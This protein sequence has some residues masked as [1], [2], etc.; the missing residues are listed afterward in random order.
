[1][2]WRFSKW[3]HSKAII[4]ITFNVWH[5]LWLVIQENVC[6]KAAALPGRRLP[7]FCC[8]KRTVLSHCSNKG[9]VRRTVTHP[10]KKRNKHLSLAP[11]PE[12]PKS[13]KCTL[14]LSPSCNW[15]THEVVKYFCPKCIQSLHSKSTMFSNLLCLGWFCCHSY[16]YLKP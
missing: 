3:S 1:M 16:F 9:G 11:N 14:P 10:Q 15:N 6:E 4:V 8:E 7:N 2:W 5:N 13:L 12:S